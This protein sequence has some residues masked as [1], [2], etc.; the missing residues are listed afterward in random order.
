MKKILIIHTKYKY[1]GGEDSNIVEELKFLKEK[2][3]VEYIEF[4]NSDKLNLFDYIGFFTNSNL[5]SNKKLKLV[6]KEF[7][8]D[9]VYIHNTWFKAGLKLFKIVKNYKTIV[10]IH[11]F[12]FE[13]TKSM[14]GK[15]HLNKDKYCLMCGFNG[16][17]FNKYFENSYLKSLFV[18]LYGKLYYKILLNGNLKLIVLTQFQ[19]NFLIEKGFNPNKIEVI[20]NPIRFTLNNKSYNSSSSYVVY[21]GLLTKQKGVLE[22]ISAWNSTNNTDLELRLIGKPSIDL[23]EDNLPENIHLLGAIDHAATISQIKNSRAVVTATRMFEGQPRLL[24]EASSLGIPSIFPKFGGMSEFFPENYP[25]AFEQFNYEDL[26]KKLNYLHNES[27]LRDLS[28]TVYDYLDNL[29]NSETI[30]SKF[31][32]FIESF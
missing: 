2:Y 32:N 4:N 9:I 16:G 7:K 24:N 5:N 26:I 14:L 19:K 25:L 30:Y 1:F 3:I 15:K 6:L 29:L 28:S 18:L 11:N 23:D 12:R 8:P 20:Y 27:K 10:K 31:D 22:L 21:A 17:I 13:C